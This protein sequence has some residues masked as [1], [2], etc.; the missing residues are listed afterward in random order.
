MSDPITSFERLYQR[1]EDI[2][3]STIAVA[4][5]DDEIVLTALAAARERSWIEPI[6]T[7]ERDRLKLMLINLG[8]DPDNYQIVEAPAGQTAEAAV[9]LVR[10][11]DADLLMKGRTTTAELL[12]AVLDPLSGIRL[13]KTAPPG[14]DG[15]T[16]PQQFQSLS[17]VAVVESPH[18]QR[19]MLLAD[20]GVN[21]EQPLP[22]LREILGNTLDLGRALNIRVPHVAALALVESVTE[23]L[24]E[25]RLARVLVKEAVHGEFGN[26]IV[27][28]PLPL[29]LALSAEVAQRKGVDS[30]IAGRTDIF[31]GPNITAVNFVVKAL[32]SIGGARGGGLVLGARAPIVL[33][34]RSDSPDTRLN[35]IALALAASLY[36]SQHPSFGNSRQITI[37]L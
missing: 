32:M 23:K 26:C 33:L 24:P 25:T 37:G 22:V 19:L 29:D 36:Y 4:A 7:G 27:E 28:G 30:R 11:G 35:S 14:G 16:P 20:G 12:Q 10:S 9:G 8:Q 5:A 31:L 17:H 15:L 34:S 13:A 6:L 3:P 18:Y 1:L 2:P 21:I